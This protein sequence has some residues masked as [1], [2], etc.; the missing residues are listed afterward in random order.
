LPFSGKKADPAYVGNISY[1]AL[2]KFMIQFLANGANAT[3]DSVKISIADLNSAYTY[4]NHFQN[5]A[6]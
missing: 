3:S 1:Y 4:A 5:V 2:P 6:A